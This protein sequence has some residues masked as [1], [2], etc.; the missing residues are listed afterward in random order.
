[1]ATQQ[2]GVSGLEAFAKILGDAT[3]IR[4]LQLLMEGRAL[5]AKA[6]A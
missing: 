1:M 6:L 3:R 5:T 4:M 2:P